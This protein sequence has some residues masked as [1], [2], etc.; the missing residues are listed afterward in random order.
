MSERVLGKP[1]ATL[2]MFLRAGAAA[3]PGASALPFVAGRGREVPDLELVLTGVEVDRRRL[4]AYDRVCGF[5]LGNE[6]PSTYL[7]VLAF[8]LHLALMTD[9]SFPFGAVGL[10]HIE[11]RIT[12][13]RPVLFGEELSL[14]VRA[15]ALEPHRRGLKFSILSEA[16]AGQELAWE[17]ES[18]NLHRTRS[19][20]GDKQEP[21]REPDESEAPPPA[22]ARWR[23]A[24][25]LGRRY[26]SVSGDHNPIHLHPV[27]A[28]LIGFP[29]AIAH[30]MWT[31]ARAL[32]ALEAELPRAY[33]V[34]VAFKRPIVLPAT[35]AF[36]E[37][38]AAQ[39]G[40]IEFGVRDARQD[41]PHL[42]GRVTATS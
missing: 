20:D 40:A 33:T 37:R 10:V 2:P 9:G 1:P 7:H 35:V 25:D 26:A 8:P 39:D 4:A 23:L 24:G 27:T 17:E 31:K 3:V 28:R 15:T 29:G 38:R 16:R 12:Q 19:A 30:G 11:N 18:V 36:G 13:H 21:N 22:T 41:T 14:R 32:A 42:V 34:E 5:T 6:V